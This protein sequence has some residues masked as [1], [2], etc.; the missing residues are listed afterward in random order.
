MIHGEEESDH[1]SDEKT[2]VF[3]E[4]L[5]A[6]PGLR[7]AAGGLPKVPALSNLFPLSGPG[8]EDSRGSQ[9]ELVRPIGRC[10]LTARMMQ[11]VE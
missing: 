2:E 6:L 5:H 10:C 9:G 4:S 7:P 11:Y 8:G 1:Q 3:G